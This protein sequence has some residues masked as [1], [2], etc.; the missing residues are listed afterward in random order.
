MKPLMTVVIIAVVAVAAYLAWQQ[1]HRPLTPGEKIDNAM[2]QLDHG[3][4]SGAVDEVT[5]QTPADRAAD[6]VNRTIDN[7]QG[8]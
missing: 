4:V 8:Q 3:T 7:A 2:N 6:S 1:M 5:A